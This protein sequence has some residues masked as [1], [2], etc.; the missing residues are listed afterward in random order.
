MRVRR[1]GQYPYVQD[2]KAWLRIDQL[3]QRAKK[4]EE[5]TQFLQEELREMRKCLPRY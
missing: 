5:I 3:E 4:Q 1:S 2:Y